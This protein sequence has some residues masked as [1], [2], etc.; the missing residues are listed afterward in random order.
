MTK[1]H[2]EQCDRDKELSEFYVRLHGPKVGKPVNPCKQ[3]QSDNQK[4]YR[5]TTKGIAAYR[6]KHLKNNYGMTVNEYN[7]MYVLQNGCCAICGT[8]F[9]DNRINVDHNHKT[10][11]VRG[12]L[13][14]FCN[15]F[16]GYVEG[17][18]GRVELIKIYLKGN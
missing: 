10:G 1:K 17:Y 2:C 13:C 14:V 8:P 6:K 16:T 15:I 4:K 7:E 18:P 9:G 3:C 11:K 12:L 5:K